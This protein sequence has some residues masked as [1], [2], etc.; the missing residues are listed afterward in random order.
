MIINQPKPDSALSYF[1]VLALR[2]NKDAP[3]API[4]DAITDDV[5]VDIATLEILGHVVGE[6]DS[7]SPPLS[8][9]ISS[10]FISHLDD[11]LAISS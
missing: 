4:D 7:L 3:P 6:F 11:V 2:D 10:G 9:D 5:I 1:F 8:F